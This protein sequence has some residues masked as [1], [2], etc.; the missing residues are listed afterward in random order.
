MNEEFK[1]KPFCE[2]DLS[3]ACVVSEDLMKLK[4]LIIQCRCLFEPQNVKTVRG[5]EARVAVLPGTQP[6]VGQTYRQTHAN[7]ILLKQWIDK[8]IDEGMI[9]ESTSPWRAGV[10]CIPKNNGQDGLAGIRVVHSFVKLNKVLAPVSWPMPRVD[11]LL[12]DLAGSQFMSCLDLRNAYHQISI[13]EGEH[14]DRVT[15][16][17]RHGLYRFRVLG[18]RM[19]TASFYFQRFADMVIG[20]LRYTRGPANTEHDHDPQGGVCEK[21]NCEKEWWLDSHEP[22]GK[23]CACMFVDDIAIAL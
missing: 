4:R 20:N 6:A 14:K 2:L 9:E 18:M 22:K 21:W 10:L 23:G 15:F 19:K 11:D 1:K 17:T 5:F 3:G 16:C 8:A 7:D 13:K 12:N